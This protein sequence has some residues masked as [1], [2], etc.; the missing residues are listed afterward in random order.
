MQF[1]YGSPAYVQQYKDRQVKVPAELLADVPPGM[2]F[3]IPREHVFMDPEDRGKHARAL[4]GARKDYEFFHKLEPDSEHT[5][6]AARQVEQAKKQAEAEAKEY[7]T[8]N[9]VYDKYW[10]SEYPGQKITPSELE[11]LASK[12]K[13]LKAHPTQ[14]YATIN[15]F[16]ASL[17]L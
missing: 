4:E 8:V 11:D 12:S 7:A 1:P 13:S 6:Q 16:F 17:G 3:P 15:A 10:S 9:R 14:L 2:F 5:K